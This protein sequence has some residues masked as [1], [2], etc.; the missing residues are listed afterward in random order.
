LTSSTGDRKRKGETVLEHKRWKDLSG[1]LLVIYFVLTFVITWGAFAPALLWLPDAYGLPFIILGAFGPMLSAMIVIR[2]GKLS[3]GINEWLVEIFDPR[4][5]GRIILAGALLLPLALGVLHFGLYAALGGRMDFS[6]AWAWYAFPVAL[7]L[8]ALLT[9]GNEEPGWRGFALPALMQRFHP[10]IAALILGAVHSVWHLP[11]MDEYDTSF[12][13]YLF[14]LT[15]LTVIFNWFYMRSRG[16]VIPV[17]FFHAGTNVIDRFIPVPG[18]VLGESGTFMLLRG[19]IYWSAAIV[20]IIAT[21]GRLGAGERR[22]E[23]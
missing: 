6:E 17:M 15:G 2:A 4:G 13:I 10:L 19:I 21:R 20:I 18:L 1:R 12:G 5:K 23:E 8:T 7:T 22:R 16:C 14:N 9:G 3:G 11:L